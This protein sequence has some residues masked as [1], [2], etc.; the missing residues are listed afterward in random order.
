MVLTWS[1]SYVGMSKVIE[2]WRIVI[3]FILF[4]VIIIVFCAFMGWLLL[5]LVYLIPTEKMKNNVKDSVYIF[6][7]EQQSYAPAGAKLDNW[8]DAMMLLGAAHEVDKNVFV[9]S[10][11]AFFDHVGSA[12]SPNESLVLIYGNSEIQDY[13]GYNYERYWHGYFLY[14]KPLLYMFNYAQIRNIISEVIVLF[15]SLLMIV[16]VK[17]NLYKYAFRFWECF[18]LLIQ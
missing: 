13:G 18:I 4:P 15:F 3:H 8:T 17:K 10:L 11:E 9:A 16:C 2:K 12:N 1:F 5:A 7:A 6:E 14:L